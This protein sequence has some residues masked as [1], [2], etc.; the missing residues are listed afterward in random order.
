MIVLRCL[1]GAI[2]TVLLANIAIIKVI[3][4]DALKPDFLFPR[5]NS[6]VGTTLVFQDDTYKLPEM[7]DVAR[8]EIRNA[9]NV[10]RYLVAQPDAEPLYYWEVYRNASEGS[11]RRID[12]QRKLFKVMSH[13]LHIHDSVQVIGKLLFGEDAPKALERVQDD[14]PSNEPCYRSMIQMFEKHCGSLS[15]MNHILFF[16]N[17]CYAGISEE[18]LYEA[19]VQTCVTLLANPWTYVFKGL[20]AYDGV[21]V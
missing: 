7:D 4:D 17:I 10:K 9:K 20:V 14:E 15:G 19:V 18:K 2:L 8:M 16:E 12:A 11:A 3:F 1:F 6:S 5:N 21:D 13:R